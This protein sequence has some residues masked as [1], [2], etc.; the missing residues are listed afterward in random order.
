MKFLRDAVDFWLHVLLLSND[1]QEPI[2]YHSTSNDAIAAGN[3]QSIPKSLIDPSNEC[4]NATNGPNSRRCWTKGFNISTDYEYQWPNTGVT[5]QV[6][7]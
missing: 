2:P 7:P 5:R 4:L 6:I 1:A 3:D